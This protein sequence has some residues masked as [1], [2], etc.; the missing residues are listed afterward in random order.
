MCTL[1]HTASSQRVATMKINIGINDRVFTATLNESKAAQE[2][3]ALLPLSLTL[4]DYASTEKI[5][6][7]FETVVHQGAAPGFDRSIGDIR[8]TRPAAILRFSA[9]TSAIRVDSSRS[10]D[11]TTAWTC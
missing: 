9:K 5:S 10:L 4:E 1:T 7:L 2:L 3:A 11:S 8:T 6:D